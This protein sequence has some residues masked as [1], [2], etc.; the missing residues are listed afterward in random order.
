[1][2]ER[3]CVIVDAYSTGRYLPGEFK[4]YGIGT[5]H[6]MSAAQ[7]PSIFQAHFNADLYDEVIRPPESMG[8]EDIVEYH[9]HALHGREL[10]FVLAG[11]E[12]GVELADSLSERLGLPSN[13]TALSAARRDK[14]RLSCAL[15]SAGVRSIRQVVSDNAV[16][17]A[18]WKREAKFDEIVIKPLNSTGTEDV[19]FCSTDADIQRALGVIVGKT[20]RVGALNRFALGQEKIKGQQYT[21][22]AVSID[23]KA[24]ITEA[25]TY[26]T[27][28]VEGASSVCSLER[29]LEGSEPIVQELSEYLERALQ[30][31]Q[32]VN[33]PAHA[34]IIIDHRGPV[35]VDFGARLQGTM[36]AKARTMALGHNHMTL[37]A[38]RY[39]DV[40]TFREYMRLRGP[41]KRKAH[42]LC[43]SLISDRGGV[44]AGY[45]GLEA[46]RK[47]PSFADAIAFVPIGE[48]LV[49]TIDLAS[50]PGIV[51]LVNSD[52]TQL[53][54]DYRKLRAMRMDQVFELVNAR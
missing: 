10:E 24:F 39:A 14:A 37:T 42:A 51:Y 29:L 33:G 45:P 9:L 21:V 19:F 46:I 49:P 28:R 36:S 4:R 40:T 1:M 15:A 27:I 44:V 25:W 13:G 48:E 16:E 32:I 11:C 31:L 23:A 52:M 7:I 41:Y 34:E 3:N 35:L 47:L 20:N 53:N 8:Y 2:K 12:T 50:T 5:V 22:N 6:V 54:D 26:D 17:I 38:W 30:A 18:N 43:V